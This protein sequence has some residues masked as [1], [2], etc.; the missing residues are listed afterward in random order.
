MSRPVSWLAGR[1]QRAPRR[2]SRAHSSP[3]TGTGSPGEIRCALFGIRSLQR[4]PPSPFCYAFLVF[5]CRLLTSVCWLRMRDL[6]HPH[7]QQRAA[8]SAYVCQPEQ[9]ASSINKT[10]YPPDPDSASARAVA[11]L[12]TF[13]RRWT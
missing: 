7:A 11:Q 5:V 12:L 10:N 8:P 9:K 4:D 6:L 3:G 2:Q 13:D 1:A